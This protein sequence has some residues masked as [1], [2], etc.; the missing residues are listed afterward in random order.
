[1]QSE[2]TRG[3]LF[4]ADMCLLYMFRHKIVHLKLSILR[5][6]MN[7]RHVTSRLTHCL[8]LKHIGLSATMCYQ[9]NIFLTKSA[10][11]SLTKII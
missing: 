5:L 6:M 10:K 3:L 8:K 11:W 1:M 2:A 4:V 7:E 9:L